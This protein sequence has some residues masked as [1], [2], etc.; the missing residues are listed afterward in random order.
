MSAASKRMRPSTMQP[1]ASL[2]NIANDALGHITQYVHMETILDVCKTC[3]QLYAQL[4]L[5]SPVWSRVVEAKPPKNG[6]RRVYPGCYF[7][8]LKHTQVLNTY[9]A[10]I[11]RVA[12]A[13]PNL[14]EMEVS[15]TSNLDLN[16][17]CHF[18]HLRKLRLVAVDF[19]HKY[20]LPL[21]RLVPQL[22]H[23]SLE[24]VFAPFR[25]LLNV[26]PSMVNLE[27]LSIELSFVSQCMLPDLP[28]LKH[29]RIVN[30]YAHEGIN[31]KFLQR[32]ANLESL[33]IE[34]GIF[35][36]ADNKKYVEYFRLLTSLKSLVLVKIRG[37]TSLDWREIQEAL[38]QL[39]V[40][41]YLPIRTYY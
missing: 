29:L 13:A 22:R 17:V 41:R 39:T 20:G 8:L 18:K 24:R 6:A 33:E 14:R 5:D 31:P 16:A 34:G 32:M 35:T 30:S 2:L 19:A 26:L 3:R 21:V 10:D 40:K 11:A 27:T 15:H 12:Q 37:F 4:E 9:C 36:C 7:S 1:P 38:P 28:N 25:S 23:L